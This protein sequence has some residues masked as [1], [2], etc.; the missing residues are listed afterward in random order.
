MQSW[1]P[2]WRRKESGMKEVSRDT[3][4]FSWATSI[5]L[6]SISMACGHSAGP[7]NAPG[8]GAAKARV[9]VSPHLGVSLGLREL[10]LEVE[11]LGGGLLQ[12]L[13]VGAL[14]AHQVLVGLLTHGGKKREVSVRPAGGG[15]PAPLPVSKPR[16]PAACW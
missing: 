13:G 14:L 2:P 12:L 1:S 5:F 11:E 8:A 4:L 10:D 7:R 9:G 3:C 6:S 15:G 16:P